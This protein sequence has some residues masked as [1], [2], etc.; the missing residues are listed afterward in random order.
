M[1]NRARDKAENRTRDKVG[2]RTGNKAGD[3]AEN[4]A[5][6]GS[7]LVEL[8]RIV[9][10]IERDEVCC[11]DLTFQQFETLRRIEGAPRLTLSSL[12]AELHIDQSTASR[13]LVRLERDGYLSKARDGADGRSVNIELTRKGRTALSSLSCDERDAFA[14]LYDRLPASQ[15]GAVVASLKVLTEALAKP[16][17]AACCEP[18]PKRRTM[19]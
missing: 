7:L 18:E 19:S 17:I 10:R 3:S 14:E 13:N 16:G 1:E 2:N 8:T 12:A 15:R 4:R 9:S 11:G 6:F 5:T